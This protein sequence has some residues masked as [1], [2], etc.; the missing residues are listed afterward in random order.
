MSFDLLANEYTLGNRNEWA[1]AFAALS[2]EAKKETFKALVRKKFPQSLAYH[3]YV[4]QWKRPETEAQARAS[5]L[6]RV[7]VFWAQNLH[8]EKEYWKVY[9][10]E[11]EQEMLVEQAA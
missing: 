3:S 5:V 9:R 6:W 2:D 8:C 7:G 4:G 1:P 10:R 11:L